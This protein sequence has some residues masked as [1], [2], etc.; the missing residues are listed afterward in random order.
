MQTTLCVPLEVKPESAS[1]LSA[2]IEALKAQEDTELA[3][4][5]VNFGRIIRDIPVLHFMSISVFNSPNYDPTFILEANFDGPPGVFWGQFAAAFDAW[6]RDML[7]CCKVPLDDDADLYNAVTAPGS[8]ARVAP[9]F[10][11][12][13]K[14]PS[15]FHHGNRGMTRDRILAEAALFVAVRDEVDDLTRQGADPY[16]GA[17]PF[18]VH[19]RLRDK[20]L[21][22]YPWLDTSSPLRITPVQR[23]GDFIR[24]GAFL[25][26]LLF[27][28]TLP[29]VILAAIAPAMVYAGIVILLGLLIFGAIFAVRKPLS[30]PPKIGQ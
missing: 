25:A 5:T 17:T 13:T 8:T 6:A 29:G 11:A 26:V 4:L 30:Y 28:L 7:R 19:K 23:A 1:R 24:F 14:Q 27:A 12:R 10:E 20:M 15:V 22:A 21:P 16:R 9:Y 18:N 3:G 2:L